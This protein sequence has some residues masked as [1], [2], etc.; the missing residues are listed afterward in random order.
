MIRGSDDT[1]FASN[2]LRY[3]RGV[4]RPFIECEVEEARLAQVLV[5]LVIVRWLVAAQFAHARGSGVA[6]V[7]RVDGVEDRSLIGVE[8]EIH[9]SPWGAR[10]DAATRG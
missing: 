2:S 6:G 10:D 4:E 5:E 9:V 3:Q 7:D 8:V 1:Q